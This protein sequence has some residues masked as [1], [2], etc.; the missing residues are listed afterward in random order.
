MPSIATAL[1]AMSTT[2]RGGILFELNI[3][4]TTGEYT[5]SG[6]TVNTSLIGGLNQPAGIAVSGSNLLW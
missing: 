3:S 1:L 6:A 5:T 4:G 2:A